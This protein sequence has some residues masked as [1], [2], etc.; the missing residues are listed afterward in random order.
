MEHLLQKTSIMD[1]TLD[2]EDSYY[3]LTQLM[4]KEWYSYTS[5]DRSIDDVVAAVE[6]FIMLHACVTLPDKG[7][8]KFWTPTPVG[9]IRYV[10]DDEMK[11]HPVS[12]FKPF[13]GYTVQGCYWS[14]GFYYLVSNKNFLIEASLYVDLQ[15]KE[16]YNYQ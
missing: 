16:Q 10:M 8:A 7:F 9:V 1:S 13:N 6:T 4:S 14:N 15:T 11:P 2:E 3:Y 5:K 12:E